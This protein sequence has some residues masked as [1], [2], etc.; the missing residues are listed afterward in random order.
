MRAA[1]AGLRTHTFPRTLF[2]LANHTS[3]GLD[4]IM[5][6]P[7]IERQISFG[8]ASST[9]GDAEEARAPRR[10]P[11]RPRTA[12]AAAAYALPERAA[13]RCGALAAAACACVHARGLSRRVGAPQSLPAMAGG[14]AGLQTGLGI[15]PDHHDAAQV[16]TS[17]HL[18]PYPRPLA[19][20]VDDYPPEQGHK[21]WLVRA[22]RRRTRALCVS[23][24]WRVDAPQSCMR[25]C[26][27]QQRQVTLHIDIKYGRRSGAP[28]VHQGAHVVETVFQ[29]AAASRAQVGFVPGPNATEFKQ[30]AWHAGEGASEG[31]WGCPDQS[32][33]YPA[34]HHML[35]HPC[36]APG[37]ETCCGG[38]AASFTMRFRS[39]AAAPHG[40]LIMAYEA[41]APP[42][43][44]CCVRLHALAGRPALRPP[45]A[46]RRAPAGPAVVAG[47]RDRSL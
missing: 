9:L 40:M 19:S 37:A 1:Q 32:M 39:F 11:V 4:C 43:R 41:R 17:L 18:A 47:T 34:M 29:C 26:L 31:F 23:C 6:K 3:D 21:G 8:S 20:L 24:C 35:L 28:G 10:T 42:A 7:P 30:L 44:P 36:R 14:H 13:R 46:H 38:P 25:P 15:C 12:A 16:M 5:D 22:R 2:Q 33:P 45:L 27:H